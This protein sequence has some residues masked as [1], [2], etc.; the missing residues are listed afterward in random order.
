MIQRIEDVTVSISGAEYRNISDAL[1]LARRH[2]R[3]RRE[4]TGN[5]SNY[6]PVDEFGAKDMAHI[7]AAMESF[8]GN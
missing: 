1:E 5:Q 2:I 4:A 7:E 6:G 3:A 8:W